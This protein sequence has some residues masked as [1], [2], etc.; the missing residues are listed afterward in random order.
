MERNMM[1]DI[2]ETIKQFFHLAF[3]ND[4]E[5]LSRCFTEHAVAYDEGKKYHGCSEIAN[6]IINAN[7][8]FQV[9]REIAKVVCKDNE[10]I[11]TAIISGSFDGSPAALDFHFIL[12]NGL[13][14]RLEI[15][16]AKE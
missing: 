1:K 11:V 14:D 10:S 7:N 9:T 12:E 2:Q 5:S 3:D 15:L 13:I 8:E 16:V 4:K 6:H